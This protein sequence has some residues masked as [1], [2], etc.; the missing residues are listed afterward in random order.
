MLDAYPYEACSLPIILRLT[1]LTRLTPGAARF[2]GL[3]SALEN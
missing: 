1:I 2:V 3:S